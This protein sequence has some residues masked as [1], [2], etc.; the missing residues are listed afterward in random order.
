MSAGSP[1]ERRQALERL[2]DAELLERTAW[3]GE[4]FG[5]FYERH[6]TAVLSYVAYR[7]YDT[8]AALDVAAA[9]F[10]AAL[11]GSRRYRADKGPARAWLFGIVNHLLAGEYDRRRRERSVRERL[12]IPRLEFE[13]EALAAAEAAIDASRTGLLRGLEQL[14]PA[15]REAVEARIVNERS[16]ADIAAEARTSEANVR[17]RVRRA[18]AKLA[19]LGGRGEEQEEES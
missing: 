3:D 6:M 12:G 8:E 11:D 18:L 13:D 4:A 17:Q 19:R 5:M 2:S 14:S 10:A 16:Y 1:F 7:L 9:V 15:E